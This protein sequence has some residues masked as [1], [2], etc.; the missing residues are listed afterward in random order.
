MEARTASV[1]VSI[2]VCL[3]SACATPTPLLGVDRAVATLGF[4]DAPV[5]LFLT[6]TNAGPV[7]RLVTVESDAAGYVWVATQQPHRMPGMTVGGVNGMPPILMPTGPLPVTARGNTRLAPGGNAIVFYELKRPVLVGDAL[8]VRLRFQSGA[9]VEA[10]VPVKDF[11][12][13]ESVID[14]QAAA[15][16]PRGEV[17]SVA[18]GRDLY[19]ANGC[20]ACH[21]LEGRGDGPVA[22][23]LTPRPRDLASPDSYRVGH[24]AETIA[25]TLAVGLPGAGSM[26]LFSHLSNHERRA[27]AL[28]IR[29]LHPSSR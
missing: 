22:A 20:A 19:R 29:S 11:A 23:T 13:V 4:A 10:S 24:D 12:D 21:G 26:P 28:F 14:P 9:T 8:A 7:D 16:I 6:I 5:A 1:W 3:A 27:M 17:P 18:L 15:R 25:R 2:V